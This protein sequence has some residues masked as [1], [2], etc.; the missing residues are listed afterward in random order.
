MLVRNPF[1]WV[2]NASI[3]FLEQPVG[4]GFSHSKQPISRV[5]NTSDDID[6]IALLIICLV[7]MHICMDE[8][9]DTY[10]HRWMN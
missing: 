3:V 2:R 6:K 7:S 8:W 10:I 9:I 5:G 4:V 1:T